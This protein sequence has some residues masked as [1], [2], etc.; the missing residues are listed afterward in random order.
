MDLP[1]LPLALAAALLSATAETAR[2]RLVRDLDPFGVAFVTAAVA[3]AFLLPALAL[4]PGPV[5]WADFGVAV[6][7]S[8]GVN[9]VAAVLVARA[10]EASDLSLVTPLRGLT[11]VFTLIVAAVVL[12]EIPSWLGAVGVV[13]ITGGTYL[14]ATAVR[15]AD[16]IGP[17]RA[18]WADRG[19][20]AMLLVALL[21]GVSSTYD[22]VGTLAS[23]PL[24]WALTLQGTIALVT[25]ARV[26]GSEDGR[27]ALARLP[28][29]AWI[30]AVV[31]GA[32]TALMLA[33]QMTALT[34]GLAGY[35]IAVKRTSILL[36]VLAGGLL[37]R[38]RHLGARLLAAGVVVAGVVMLALG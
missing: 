26:V 20:R 17:L 6:L 38:E 30:A 5:A 25:G 28:R 8:G 34:V 33:A 3:T 32:A 1:W 23:S 19:A 4:E 24:L 11:P 16:A 18:L 14:L 35:V 31:T 22:K 13:T 2:K 21:Y 9:V 10:Y 7:V 12:A 37:F 36:T 27:R 15:G 29:A